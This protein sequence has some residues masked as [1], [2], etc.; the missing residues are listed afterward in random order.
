MKLPDHPNRCEGVSLVE[1]TLG[2]SVLT[3]GVL[4]FYFTLFAN[5]RATNSTADLDSV[6]VA[7]EDTSEIMRNADFATAYA[8]YNGKT[9]TN[10]E[11]KGPD[12]G[13]APLVVTCHVD[14]TQLPAEFGPVVDIDGDGAMNTTDC[15][16]SYNILPVQLTL[17]YLDSNGGT[18]VSTTYMILGDGTLTNGGSTP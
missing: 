14:E 12:G 8:S 13:P 11:L 10:G 1:L 2:L 5:V 9:Y 6:R 17:T 16:T 18:Q 3:T 4:G 7:L 15:S